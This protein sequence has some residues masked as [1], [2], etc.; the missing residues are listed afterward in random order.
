MYTPVQRKMAKVAEQDAL[1]LRSLPALEFF[2]SEPR[3]LRLRRDYTSMFFLGWIPVEWDSCFNF[4]P[5]NLIST[6]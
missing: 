4:L 2:D 3:S 1:S 5:L 6:R